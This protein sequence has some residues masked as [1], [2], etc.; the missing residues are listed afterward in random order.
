M[1]NNRIKSAVQK[2]SLTESGK[3]RILYGCRDYELTVSKRSPRVK[4]T[5]IAATI[6]IL[7]L[8]VGAVAVV[9]LRSPMTEVKT[10]AGEDLEIVDTQDSIIF[11]PIED[12]EYIVSCDSVTGG[13]TEVYINITVK[14]SDGAIMTDRVS[15]GGTLPFVF[16]HYAELKLSDGTTSTLTFVATNDSNESVFHMEGHTILIGCEESKITSLLNGATVKLGDISCMIKDENGKYVEEFVLCSLTRPIT[17]RGNY[18]NTILNV[19]FEP[20]TI[21][22]ADG[23]ITFR[24]AEMKNVGIVIYGDCYAQ[25]ISDLDLKNAFAVLDNGE[26]MVLGHKTVAGVTTEGDFCIGWILDTV[27]DPEKIAE[28]HVNGT[29]IKLK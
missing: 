8:T 1:N 12:D 23:D 11:E 28:I 18:K 27:I 21:S 25:D 15:G 3:A 2:L 29:V 26:Q 5:L 7:M 6:L 14:R 24:S 20:V 10:H 9:S 22:L 19:N 4:W 13:G 17:L 16:A